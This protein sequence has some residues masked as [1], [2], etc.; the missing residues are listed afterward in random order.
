LGI[1]WEY[2]GWW[3]GRQNG[4]PGSANSDSG[5]MMPGQVRITFNNFQGL[6]LS[7]AVKQSIPTQRTNLPE[8]ESVL[9]A[10]LNVAASPRSLLRSLLDMITAP[11]GSV[12]VSGVIPGV[13]IRSP[14]PDFTISDGLGA[15]AGAFVNFGAGG[16]VYFWNKRPDG[17][18]GLYGTLSPGLI[19]NIAASVGVQLGFLFGKAADT[20]GGD[21]IVVSLDV[22]I[23]GGTIAGMII[24][25]P[26]AGG[27]WPPTGA[28]LAAWKP[29]V[30]GIG[31]GLSVGVGGAAGRHFG[32]AQP[33]LVASL[34]S[35]SPAAFL[36]GII[37]A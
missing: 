6:D 21:S 10:A 30:E 22:D 8:E 13:K 24:L 14:S 33:H 4:N 19:T 36:R 18:V 5:N 12:S 29:E 17:E 3:L 15:Q 27:M 35:G 25:T 7:R 11:L 34:R 28:A 20:L 16:G 26:P 23:G 31:L 1:Y 32:N 2:T 37:W 9:R